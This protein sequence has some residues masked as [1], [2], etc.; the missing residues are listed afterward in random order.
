[1]LDRSA[2]EKVVA[3]QDWVQAPAYEGKSAAD[4]DNGTVRSLARR[5]WRSSIS[6][7]KPGKPIRRRRGWAGSHQQHALF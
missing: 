7:A 1:M 6:N 4:I 5:P 2:N 3:Y